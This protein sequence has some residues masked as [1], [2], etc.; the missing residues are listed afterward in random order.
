RRGLSDQRGPGLRGFHP[1]ES[2]IGWA[3]PFAWPYATALSRTGD[4]RTAANDCSVGEGACGVA[5]VTDRRTSVAGA[6]MMAARVIELGRRLY[7]GGRTIGTALA[8]LDEVG[9]LVV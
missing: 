2:V 7:K 6:C 4:R 8:T 9:I 3:F 1:S 5:G